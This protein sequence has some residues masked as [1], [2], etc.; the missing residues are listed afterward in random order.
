MLSIIPLFECVDNA[1][2][3]SGF[4]CGTTNQTTVYVGISEQFF[5]V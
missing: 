3:V 1:F 4:Q 5:C 2:E